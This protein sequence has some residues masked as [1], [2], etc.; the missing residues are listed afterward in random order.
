MLGRGVESAEEGY[1]ECVG[2]EGE[3][4]ECYEE[5]LRVVLVVLDFGARGGAY[6]GGSV[7]QDVERYAAQSVN[8]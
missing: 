5:V 3:E 8:G 4:V 2:E 1:G 6:G 7:R